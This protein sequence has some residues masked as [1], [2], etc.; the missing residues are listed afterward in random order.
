MNK[1]KELIKTIARFFNSAIV[2]D[3]EESISLKVNDVY[4]II[5]L[6]QSIH[7]Y[8]NGVESKLYGGKFLRS[9]V[10]FDI[11]WTLPYVIVKCREKLNTNGISEVFGVD[12]Y[13]DDDECKVI[14]DKD[15]FLVIDKKKEHRFIGKRFVFNEVVQENI[16]FSDEKLLLRHLCFYL[17]THKYL[18]TN[19]K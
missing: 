7:I 8:N 18:L 10:S 13:D 4:R 16:N 1:S 11:L 12:I 17:F 5:I 3:S 2:K 9:E 6:P 14:F 19:K 15:N